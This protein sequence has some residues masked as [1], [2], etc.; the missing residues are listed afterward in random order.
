MIRCIVAGGRWYND[1]DKAFAYLDWV[2]PDENNI[3]IVSGG[4]PPRKDRA[5]GEVILGADRIGELYA[6]SRG[7][8]L[9]II[10]ADWTIGRRAGPLRNEK[11]A[12]YA[13]H[14][15]AFPGGK[16]TASMIALAKKHG[17]SIREVK[18]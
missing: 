2:L 7:H 1:K 14:L 10:K 8:G 12:I 9:K 3:Q 5:T 13:T 18:A 4:C 11:M 15:V 17:L 16:G 6:E